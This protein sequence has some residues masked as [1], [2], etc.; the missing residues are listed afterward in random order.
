VCVV[1]IMATPKFRP[2]LERIPMSTY[3]KKTASYIEIF[4]TYVFS[5]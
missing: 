5:Y 4:R 3:V 1:L 2:S